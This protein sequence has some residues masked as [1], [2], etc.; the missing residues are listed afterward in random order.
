MQIF[1]GNIKNLLN[2]YNEIPYWA[3]DIATPHELRVYKERQMTTP[4]SKRK[5]NTN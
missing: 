5:N 2:V 3:G 1:D 4:M